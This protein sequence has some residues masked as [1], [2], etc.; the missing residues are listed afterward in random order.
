LN[1]SAAEGAVIQSAVRTALRLVVLAA[2]SFV[3]GGQSTGPTLFISPAGSD[4]ANNCQSATKPCATF[5]HAAAMTPVGL[6]TTVYLADGQYYEQVNL[7]H[8]KWW[9]L[10]GNCRTEGRVILTADENKPAIWIQ[11][12]ATFQ[13]QCLDVT[14]NGKH[15]IA[16]Q[17][18]QYA[19]ADI[20]DK[21][22]FGYFPSGTLLHADESSRINCS[23]AHSLILSN[24]GFSEGVS[25]AARMVYAHDSSTVSM[26]CTITATSPYEFTDTT[27][28][29]TANGLVDF[30]S[31]RIG[32]ASQ[33]ITVSSPEGYKVYLD[34]SEVDGIANVPGKVTGPNVLNFSVVH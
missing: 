7:S 9:Q 34:H 13:G 4:E 21:V 22:R 31:F 26:G 10:F 16:L 6:L 19:I 11:D 14:S 1:A 5:A 12:H 30:Q 18:R 15:A 2:C 33:P 23:G 32:T 17:T 3:L 8:Y 25:G 27:V 28:L 24:G 20:V 29:A